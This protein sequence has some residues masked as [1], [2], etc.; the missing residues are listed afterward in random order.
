MNSAAESPTA[1]L[2]AL[3]QRV[4]DGRDRPPR[5][6]GS[7]ARPSLVDGHERQR[8]L[9]SRR[10]ARTATGRRAPAPG[11]RRSQPPPGVVAGAA[12]QRDPRPSRAATTATLAA[13]PP[14]CGTNRVGLGEIVDR[15]LADQVDQRLAQAQRPRSGVGARSVVIDRDVILAGGCAS[16]STRSRSPGRPSST[17][18]PPAARR[19][20]RPLYLHGV[21][22]SSD[23]WT[24][25][26]GATGGIAPDLIGFGRSGKGGHLDYS[27]D[28]LRRLPRAAA[29]RRSASTRVKLVGHDW[30]A[31]GRAGVRPAPPGAGRADRA[32]DAAAAAR[33]LRLAAARRARGARPVVGELLM[34]SVNRSVLLAR[35]CAG[36]VREDAV[37]R[38]SASPR[39]GSSST[40]APSGRSCACTA[41]SPSELAAG[42]RGAGR[43]RTAQR[44]SSGASAI[45]GCP[46]TSPTR[47][48]AAPAR[49]PSLERV[50]GRRPLAVARPAG[51]DRPR[52]GVPG[53][54]DEAA[55]STP[56]RIAADAAW[57]RRSC[58]IVYV[59]V[60]PPS[61]DLAAHL[62]R[63]KLF[64]AE[65]F[66]IWNNWWYAG[67]HIAGYSVLFPAVAAALT[68]QLGGGA[69]RHRDRGAVRAAG[70]PAVRAGRVARG[71][72][73]SAPRT[74]TNLFTGRLAFAFGLLPAVAAA[75]AL[76]A[77][78]AR[79]RRARWRC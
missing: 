62:L 64:R 39:S 73:G 17:A 40:R 28:G 58:A 14:K 42:G 77:P 23:D 43:A 79:A 19:R 52:R 8:R 74:A 47:Y 48:A 78:A 69:R 34:G 2:H 25:V 24:R 71:R 6:S 1:S 12:G 54:G 3:G 29:G 4:H 18:A 65:G 51:G 72:C 76:A 9:A 27:L 49:R 26:P 13:A 30:G 70:P 38:R 37:V 60:S 33:R 16:T 46:R 59:I 41:R 53:A 45:R 21:P 61:L 75:L 15:A 50:A 63:A 31:G 5:R 44:W 10:S 35:C 36:C 20:L 7:S 67:H 22:T 57:R 66:G 11:A 68:P 32:L 55:S 56:R